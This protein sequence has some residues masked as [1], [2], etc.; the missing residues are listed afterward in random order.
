[1][2]VKDSDTP[3]KK[4]KLANKFQKNKD[5]KK[6]QKEIDKLNGVKPE[7]K[8]NKEDRNKDKKIES[9]GKKG[10]KTAAPPAPPAWGGF[11]RIRAGKKGK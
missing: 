10:A 4:E 11:K 7:Y 5:K 2:G 6:E 1:V 8:G 9:K 3:V